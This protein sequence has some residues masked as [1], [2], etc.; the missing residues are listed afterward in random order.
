MGLVAHSGFVPADPRC[1]PKGAWWHTTAW[2]RYWIASSHIAMQSAAL[3]QFGRQFLTGNDFLFMKERV[4]FGP[5]GNGRLPHAARMHLWC[6]LSAGL[7]LYHVM[8]CHVL[9]SCGHT[10]YCN[11]RSGE[12]APLTRHSSA[13]PY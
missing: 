9:M 1:Q 10:R 3:L 11:S 7:W 8:S 6:L 4:N 2:F 5:G 12:H 13:P